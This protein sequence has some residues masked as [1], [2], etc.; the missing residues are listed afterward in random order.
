M[1][2]YLLARYMAS[3]LEYKLGKTSKTYKR[4]PVS[5]SWAVYRKRRTDTDPNGYRHYFAKLAKKIRISI[6]SDVLVP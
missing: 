2:A 3:P 4:N 6:E 5:K 1:H